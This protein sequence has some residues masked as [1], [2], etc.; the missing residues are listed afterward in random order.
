[1]EMHE[2]LN[3]VRSLY[4]IDRHLLPELDD[5]QWISFRDDPPRYTINTDK[6]QKEA[7]WREV[8]KRQPVLGE[9]EAFRIGAPYA[10]RY[11]DDH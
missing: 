4:N 9:I 7:I 3:R 11:S 2:F 5:M 10:G 6:V 1:M 8:E